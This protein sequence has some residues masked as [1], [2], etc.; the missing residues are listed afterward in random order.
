MKLSLP[1][2]IDNSLMQIQAGIKIK[3]KT[4]KVCTSQLG[5]QVCNL[6]GSPWHPADVSVMCLETQLAAAFIPGK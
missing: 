2:L 4:S 6:V 3:T 1:K 5:S